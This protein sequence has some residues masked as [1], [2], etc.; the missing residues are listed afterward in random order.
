MITNLRLAASFLT[1]VPLHRDPDPNDPDQD[2]PVQDDSAMSRAVPWFMVVGLVLGT[3]QALVYASL[4]QILPALLAA[5]LAIA[6]LAL[7]TGAFHHDGLADMADAFGGGWTVDQRLEI[8]K[9]SRLGTYGVTA[10]TLA[11]VTEVAALSAVAAGS[12]AAAVI[13]AHTLS[14]AMSGLAMIVGR[15]A[16]ASGLGVDYLAGLPRSAVG[17]SVLGA[18]GIA[19]VVAGVWALVASIVAG[20]VMVMVLQ[21]ANRKI[22]GI[23]GDVLGAVQQLTKLAVL[24]TL[25]AVVSMAANGEY[26]VR[27]GGLLLGG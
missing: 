25:V 18:V 2:D 27:W 19:A 12:G 6:A 21:L 14:R 13:A 26:A 24:I 8:L 5:V 1:R 3:M 22:G 17:A 11:I 4:L 23:S 9:D 10:L 16:K 7:I 15:P 20:L